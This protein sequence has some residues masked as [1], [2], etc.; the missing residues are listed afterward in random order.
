MGGK[1]GGRQGEV[2]KWQNGAGENPKWV[3]SGLCQ[4]IIFIFPKAQNQWKNWN[5]LQRRQQ[6]HKLTVQFKFAYNWHALC[7]RQY[8]SM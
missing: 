8:R 6:E 7:M 5:S 3:T 1:V 2:E 4:S